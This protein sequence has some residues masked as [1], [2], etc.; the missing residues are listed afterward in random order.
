MEENNNNNDDDTSTSTTSNNNNNSSRGLEIVP[1]IE[2]SLFIDNIKIVI[3][4]LSDSD[5]DEDED[6]DGDGQD[7]EDQDEAIKYQ[8]TCIHNSCQT[9][10]NTWFT[11][12]KRGDR[13]LFSTR[14]IRVKHDNK[15]HK[16]PCPNSASCP[17][18]L[19]MPT[20]PCP[21][22]V[23][24]RRIT[25]NR[26]FAHVNDR[27]LHPFCPVNSCMACKA[28]NIN[29]YNQNKIKNQQSNNQNNNNNRNNKRKKNNSK[30]SESDSSDSSDSDS[31]SDS[32]SS[33]SDEE[34]KEKKLKN[35]VR[36][37]E[38]ISCINPLHQTVCSTK[39]ELPVSEFYFVPGSKRLRVHSRFCKR[40]YNWRTNNAKI[41]RLAKAKEEEEKRR[42]RE[43]EV[44][45]KEIVTHQPLKKRI[46]S[47]FIANNSSISI[48][49][50]SS[51]NSP[52][53]P[54]S[55][56]EEEVTVTLP[57]PTASSSSSSSSSSLFKKNDLFDLGSLMKQAD[58]MVMLDD[59]A[60]ST[61]S[62]PIFNLKSSPTKTTPTIK[63]N[64][65]NTTTT[66][67]KNQQRQ[68]QETTK[69]CTNEYHQVW[70]GTSPNDIPVSNFYRIDKRFHGKCVPCFNEYGRMHRLKQ[71]KGLSSVPPLDAPRT[72]I[73]GPTSASTTTIVTK[74]KVKNAT[75]NTVSKN[76]VSKNNIA[77]K[78]IVSKIVS[79]KKI[80][81][82]RPSL[83][84]DD[85]QEDSNDEQ[86]QQQ[87]STEKFS[88]QP[89]KQQQQQMIDSDI[90]I[91]PDS[92]DDE[93]EDNQYTDNN[94]NNNNN[95]NVNINIKIQQTI[96]NNMDN[97]VNN[98]NNKNNNNN[99]NNFN[100]KNKNGG[101]QIRDQNNHFDEMKI[102]LP[103]SSL[104]SPSSL[105]TTTT[106]T[107]TTTMTT[108]TTTTTTTEATPSL[109]SSSSST[110]LSPLSPSSLP[111]STSLS[112][113]PFVSPMVT[114]ESIIPENAD[115][116]SPF[117]QQ[118][119]SILM[120]K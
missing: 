54:N 107:T 114:P 94:N 37:D 13:F 15:M 118:L 68:Q 57:P 83:Y 11:N 40:C 35:R 49:S 108:T 53:S 41:K 24:G 7:E 23:C 3:E 104:S 99:N 63:N 38:I 30:D 33:S 26:L 9:G 72:K 21:H 4:V 18:C 66:T 80:K 61:P 45:G 2:E 119:I 39:P 109:S 14:G 51:S 29:L 91:G 81:A 97:S 36:R 87:R 75:K 115:P 92:Y 88:F 117:I 50:S 1:Y 111:T 20:K 82:K 44:S 31:D 22:I 70:W 56:S 58:N 10:R 25:S 17:G 103:T 95:N 105:A 16:E 52:I 65:N 101:N 85:E 106:T 8:K 6:E 102:D 76:V 19:R 12:G 90:E 113:V 93:D 78:N 42:Q 74:Q 89:T 47:S 48:S 27:I 67:T 55:S 34:E 86:N 46:K 98:N 60:T 79:K 69:N 77:S 120:K 112:I 116:T 73:K 59:N 64:N 5:D 84:S 62:I 28:I 100:N 110:C 32:S 43:K 96:N 71:R